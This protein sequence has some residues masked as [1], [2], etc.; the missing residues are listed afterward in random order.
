MGISDATELR[1]YMIEKNK[2]IDFDSL[3][4][5]LEPFLFRAADLELVRGFADRTLRLPG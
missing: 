2:L 4:R 3:T 1:D 5:D